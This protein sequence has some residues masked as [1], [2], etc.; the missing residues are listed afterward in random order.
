MR[1]LSLELIAFGP[2]SGQVLDFSE[3]PSGVH[4]VYGPNEAGKSSSLRALRSFLYGFPRTTSDDQRHAAKDLRIGAKIESGAGETHH[5]IRRRGIKNSLRESDDRTT[6]D[7]EQ[8]DRVLG[9]IDEDQFCSRFGLHYEDL[10]RGGHDIATGKGELGQ[11]LF[12]AASGV[13]GLG[14]IQQQL[15]DEAGVLFRPKGRT[16]QI[17]QTISGL[18]DARKAVQEATLTSDAF[19]RCERE[20]EEARCKSRTLSEAKR[21]VGER[22]E[23]LGR[24]RQALKL[25]PRR[26]V[27][28]QKIADLQGVP[29]LDQDWCDRRR[30]VERELLVLDRDRERWETQS[31]EVHQKIEAL[32]DTSVDPVLLETARTLADQRSALLS[33]QRQAETKRQEQVFLRGA[34]VTRLA[35]LNRQLEADDLSDWEPL[36]LQLQQRLSVLIESYQKLTAQ[37]ETIRES[38]DRIQREMMASL[39]ES[40]EPALPSL[41]P[42]AERLD[43]GQQYDRLDQ[44]IAQETIQHQKLE[45]QL[46]H[47]AQGLPFWQGAVE[48]WFELKWPH[49]SRIEVPEEQW[50][51]LT[52]EQQE[53]QRELQSQQQEIEKRQ[54][55]I[56]AL[57]GQSDLPDPGQLAAKRRERDQLWRDELKPN[58]RDPSAL[59]DM[60]AAWMMHGQA[61]ESLVHQVDDMA[62]RLLAASAEL[63]RRQSLQDD[64]ASAR[65]VLASIQHRV[66]QV[67]ERYETW[68]S[69]WV[70]LWPAE[71][72]VVGAPPEMRDWIQQSASLIECQRALE[73]QQGMVQ[74]AVEQRNALIRGLREALEEVGCGRQPDQTSE[75]RAWLRLG[76]QHLDELREKHRDRQ[77]EEERQA[78]FRRELN[79]EK[80]RLENIDQE[81]ETWSDAWREAIEPLGVG[82]DLLPDTAQRSVQSLLEVQQEVNHWRRLDLEIRSFENQREQTLSALAEM[83]E[84]LGLEAGE[85]WE[86]DLQLL[87][88]EVQSQVLRLDRLKD[89]ESR[90][91]VLAEEG[92][93]LDSKTQRLSVDRDWL[94]QQA[95]VDSPDQWGDVEEKSFAKRDAIRQLDQV[96][97]QFQELAAESGLVGE[98]G[99]AEW[100]QRVAESSDVDLDIQIQELTLEEARLEAELKEAN[101]W[102]G[103]CR[104]TL[105][106]MDG[107]DA[108]AVAQEEVESL[109]AMLEQQV[110]EYSQLMVAA[111][112]LR[113]TIQQYQEKHQ[114]PI[115][116]YASRYFKKLTCGSFEGLIADLDEQGNVVLLGVRDGDQRVLITQM[117]EGTQ[118]QLY[119]ALRLASLR[120][121]LNHHEPWP[122]IVDDILIKFDDRRALATLEVLEEIGKQSQVILFTHH[123]HL[124]ELAREKFTAGSVHFHELVERAS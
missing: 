74:A 97:Q 11:L 22:R 110:D 111:A 77:Q 79:N 61:Y 50:R 54:S 44:E 94:N 25:L 99:L 90:L 82:T 118:D 76:Q 115:L 69:E 100:T 17:N 23:L 101:E 65:D 112:V 64:L 15:E 96:D 49:V 40:G 89:L 21:E 122:F 66:A 108:A 45:Q 55:A 41:E 51:Q 117:S 4:L 3:T 67:Q 93:D 53:L 48:R 88:E 32:G 24:Y 5:W 28:Q 47:L 91:V 124:I 60:Q 36:S 86:V 58:L 13:A 85:D 114:G 46:A 57:D 106:Q 116:E 12:A 35:D 20:L 59:A 33:A 80:S 72:E 16:L 42:L 43:L 92:Q 7:P 2:F 81:I 19:Q 78:R 68:H 29:Q 120:D 83:L 26:T 9:G 70:A 75:W 63:Q 107:N 73:E 6:V 39:P 87:A 1:W 34:I 121:Q 38:A 104:T 14:E 105:R 56:D 18:M 52:A 95:G 8:L 30:Q 123:A 62:D 103:E 102:V 109:T 84:A 10:V 27:L 98:K 31:R 37:Q 71:L 119:L 113:A